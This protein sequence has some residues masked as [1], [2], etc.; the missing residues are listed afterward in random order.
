[1]ENLKL[2]KQLVGRRLSSIYLYIWPPYLED[3]MLSV[4]MAV[5]MGFEGY[6]GAIYKVA[7]NK[8]DC[9]TPVVQ[10]TS[11]P[12]SLDGSFV[13][14][15]IKSWMTGEVSEIKGEEIFDMSADTAFQ[16]L[17]G[18][19]L[20]S[21]ELI[22]LSGGFEPFG[23]KLIF[24]NDYIQV[25]PISDGGTVETSTFNCLNNLL[26]FEEMGKYKLIRISDIPT[27]E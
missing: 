26:N 13:Y 10:K 27:P 23:I 17:I 24:D 12:D 25:T 16:S 7:I 11:L 6:E 8:E 14:Q 3:N 4:D 22:T 20:A 21:V 1:M 5:G 2:I 18:S 15:R 9:W 19:S